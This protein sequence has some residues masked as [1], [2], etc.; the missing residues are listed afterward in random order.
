MQSEHF[1]LK[2]VTGMQ[3]GVSS[4]L[5]EYETDWYEVME[6]LLS[7]LEDEP[8]NCDRFERI[9]SRDLEYWAR[10]QPGGDT[11]DLRI[12]VTLE[13]KR[14]FPPPQGTRKTLKL[15]FNDR[16]STVVIFH[17]RKKNVLRSLKELA[18][19]AVA[20]KLRSE[21]DAEL[22]EIPRTLVP[23]VKR[24]Y[25]NC[26]TPRYHRAKV[27]NCP[28]WCACKIW[29]HTYEPDEPVRAAAV[30]KNSSQRTAA[31]KKLA[32]K[33]A[34]QK[35]K[36]ADVAKKAKK[37]S[38]ENTAKAENKSKSHTKK[39]EKKMKN[40][41]LEKRK[42]SQ[43]NNKSLKSKTAGNFKNVSS[44]PREIHTV[45]SGK[46]SSIRKKLLTMLGKLQLL[47]AKTLKSLGVKSAPNVSAKQV[48]D[49]KMKAKKHKSKKDHDFEILKAKYDLLEQ[50]LKVIEKKSKLKIIKTKSKNVK[51]LRAEERTIAEIEDLQLNLKM[52][53]KMVRQL[54]AKEKA[55]SKKVSKSK[56]EDTEPSTSKTRR[57]KVVAEDPAS[58][59]PRSRTPSSSKSKVKSAAAVN[60]SPALNTRSAKH[61]IPPPESAMKRRRQG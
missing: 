23:D 36:C 43:H 54:K 20:D 14:Y 32:S 35:Q 56:N 29:T 33:K 34:K 19:I 59:K 26:W 38:K 52:V 13:E 4:K 50:K 28:D 25:M 18:A 37:K 49:M 2:F 16:F 61:A 7:R 12:R 30:K 31:A 45:E 22:L 21:S 10:V 40:G 55:T 41:G 5:L 15:T 8:E 24:A 48:M 51:N 27:V 9:S 47:K 58:R 39:A 11:L 1:Q 42:T 3:C 44:K 6:I 57:R 53:G 17:A 60:S 46:L